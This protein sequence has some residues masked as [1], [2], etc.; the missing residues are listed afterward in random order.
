M[1]RNMCCK[2]AEPVDEEEHV[3]DCCCSTEKGEDD[4]GEVSRVTIF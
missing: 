2:G 3:P 4:T 1:D